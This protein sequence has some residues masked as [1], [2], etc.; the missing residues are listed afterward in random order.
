MYR[1]NLKLVAEIFL[2]AL[3]TTTVILATLA[4]LGASINGYGSDRSSHAVPIIGERSNGTMQGIR[5]T[6]TFPDSAPK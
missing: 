2:L 5:C 1:K 4:F 3:G 6:T